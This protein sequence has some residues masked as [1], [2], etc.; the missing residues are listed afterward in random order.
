[1]S[2][3]SQELPQEQ[4]QQTYSTRPL[5]DVLCLNLES[6]H[7]QEPPD[8]LIPRPSIVAPNYQSY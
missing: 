4:S 1:M 6:V 5:P 2:F 7:Q 8:G 3:Q